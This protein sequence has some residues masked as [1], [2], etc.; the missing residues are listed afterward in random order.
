M[1]FSNPTEGG[2]TE[3]DGGRGA[4]RLALRALGLW[5]AGWNGFERWSARRPGVSACVTTALWFLLAVAIFRPSFDTNDDPAMEMIAAGRGFCTAP[6]E[7]LVF[8]HVAI[9]WGLKTLYTVFPTVP[10]YGC[11]LFATQWAAHAAL[12]A[13]LYANGYQRVR[14]ALYGLYAG[15][16]GLYFLNFLQFTTTAYLAAQSGMILAWIVVRR[17]LERPTAD[18]A[19][20]SGRNWGV[21]E[22][23]GSRPT[24]RA[25]IGSGWLLGIGAAL[26]LWSSLIRWPVFFL[27][28]ALSTP[29]FGVM[30]IGHLRRIRLW[31]RVATAGLALGGI[32]YGLVLANHAYYEADPRWRGFYDFNELRAHFNDLGHFPYTTE[33]AA[34]FTKAGWSQNDYCMIMSWFYDDPSVFNAESFQ[35]IMEG[36]EWPKKRGSVR[37]TMRETLSD[38]YTRPLFLAMIAAL[39]CIPAGRYDRATVGL[40]VLGSLGLIVAMTVWRKPPPSRV[41]M[42][43]FAFPL[44]FAIACSHVRSGWGGGAA[45]WRRWRQQRWGGLAGRRPTMA[46]LAAATAMVGL[47]LWAVGNSVSMQY[48]RSRENL[49]R[50]REF[51]AAFASLRVRPDQLYIVWGYDFAFEQLRPTDSLWGMR[52]YRMLLMGWPQQAPF[53]R[54]MK[55]RFGLDNLLRDLIG[56]EDVFFIASSDCTPLIKTYAREHFQMEVTSHPVARAGKMTVTRLLPGDLQTAMRVRGERKR[57]QAGADGPR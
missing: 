30:A 33:T 32:V 37:Q 48:T 41:Y 39:L 43:L 12:L 51:W 15:T 2:A 24:T 26:L 20:A 35:R 40:L 25:T 45:A 57:G 38:K 13:G 27:V 44:A 11:Y 3:T 47:G 7:H 53:H 55:Q 36:G 52:D 14:L 5:R 31:E 29:A 22:E 54:E 18:D 17:A 46:A 10:W 21:E 16:A 49:N 9:G 42:T 28:A 19:A 56:R 1:R 23:T 50:S 34:T 6:D 8:T 4:A